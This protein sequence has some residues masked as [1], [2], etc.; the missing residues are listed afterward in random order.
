M[1]DARTYQE[2][3]EYVLLQG[4]NV[5]NQERYFWAKEITNQI[6]TYKFNFSDI[7]IFATK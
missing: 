6:K 7:S 1:H 5:S 2:F 3:V 4:M